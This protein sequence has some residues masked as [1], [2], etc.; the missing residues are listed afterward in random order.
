MRTIVPRPERLRFQPEQ[1]AGPGPA[2]Q[3][4]LMEPTGGVQ[5]SAVGVAF[6]WSL[7]VVEVGGKARRVAELPEFPEW[8]EV[9][10]VQPVMEHSALERQR[11]L[12][13]SP[14][15]LLQPALP[16]TA[17]KAIFQLGPAEFPNT[18]EGAEGAEAV[19]WGSLLALVV[20]VCMAQEAGAAGVELSPA[21][22]S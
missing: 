18:A 2:R 3:A 15:E 5:L 8:A 20:A 7:P 11:L 16:V 22:G 1:A 10:A 9:E 19:R 12:V 4:G 6:I 14:G 17:G 21:L 13:E